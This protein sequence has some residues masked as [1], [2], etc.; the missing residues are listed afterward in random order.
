MNTLFYRF[1]VNYSKVAKKNQLILFSREQI[2]SRLELTRSSKKKSIEILH[3][4]QNKG[5]Q[6]PDE[7]KK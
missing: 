5:N 4:M 7:Q 1:Y 2:W 3:F 6:G